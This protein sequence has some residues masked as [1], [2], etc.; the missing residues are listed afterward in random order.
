LKTL[1]HVLPLLL[2]AGFLT[3]CAWLPGR[4]A[5]EQVATAE[6]QALFDEARVAAQTDPDSGRTALTDFLDR[7]PRGPLSDDAARMLA[8]LALADGDTETAIHWLSYVVRQHKSGD[9][10]DD[11]MLLL[12]RL[13]I[14]RGRPEEA[15]R[16][17]RRARF[18]R[19]PPEQQLVAFRLLA[20][21]AEDGVDRLYW[22][23]SVRETERDLAM[24]EA[25][26]DTDRQIDA[27][28]ATLSRDDLERAADQLDRR[29]PAG[30]VRIRMGQLDLELG[31]ID[32]ARKELA[33]LDR[34]E[35]APE[36]VALQSELERDIAL[37]EQV[38]SAEGGLPTFEEVAAL[39]PP[40][41]NSARGVIGVV[42]P[43][44]GDF[45]AYGE[46]C[47]QGILLAA[48]IFDEMGGVPF[49]P[50]SPPPDERHGPAAVDAPPPDG[51]VDGPRVRL[52]IRDSAGDPER[53]AAAVRALAENP[54]LVAIVGPLLSG[55]SDA[56]AQAAQSA[57]V[58]LITLATR[59]EVA[60]G[61][62]WVFRVRTTPRD[63]VRAV[64]DY[65]TGKLD[66]KRFAILYPAT[67]YG[68]GTRDQFWR[69]VEERGGAVVAVSSYDPE[70]TD[71]AEPIR[72][73]IGYPL[74]TADEK[75]ALAA[76]SEELRKLRRLE[77]EEAAVAREELMS[78]LGPEGV[79]LPPIVDF[80]A[81]FVPDTYEN[82][83]LIAPQLAFHEVRNVRL[84][85]TG[86]W[87]DP[88]LVRIARGHVSGAVI[89]A[90]FDPSSHFEF[91]ARF[92]ESFTSTFGHEPD[93]FAAHAYDATN[94]VLIQL[95]AGRT[96]RD[97]LRDGVLVT[98][99][100]PG[101]S[102]VL[103]FLPDGNAQKRPYLMGVRRSE[104]ISLD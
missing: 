95:A 69:G 33:R 101:A 36:Y 85:G 99:G 7:Y 15:R 86:D 6:E 80:D 67:R 61:R 1:R 40:S 46:R 58:P 83:V 78:Q 4:P 24:E 66:A 37:R 82:V 91:V 10:A 32:Q 92:V 25:V 60:T 41:T 100:Y 13:E 49:D 50:V 18:T 98:R 38:M 81:L 89:A 63:E 96:D 93:V 102:G 5:H 14:E 65:A 62:D 23:A 104:F 72:R 48:G 94:L 8:D 29:I 97:D 17:L 90:P 3:S 26:A 31:D 64:V 20:E 35:M 56:A 2:I 34:I 21:S 68:R 88:D 73:L 75:K 42:L 87:L 54:D 27:L 77:P 51:Y 19:W 45:A 39:P 70:A 79:P 22:L 11:A 84:L 55:A 12:A 76:R 16:M 103:S 44:T 28:V 47:L 57:D 53:A 59:D 9:Q 71:F 43:L 30:R 52:V 74:L